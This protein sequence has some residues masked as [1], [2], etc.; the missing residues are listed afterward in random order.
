[1]GSSWSERSYARSEWSRFLHRSVPNPT[2]IAS[3]ERR[4]VDSPCHSVRVTEIAPRHCPYR[5]D[6]LHIL[7]REYCFR[8]MVNGDVVAGRSASPLPEW[9]RMDT[10]YSFLLYAMTPSSLSNNGSDELMACEARKYSSARLDDESWRYSMPINNRG[11]WDLIII[12]RI[13]ATERASR[14][15]TQG[16]ILPRWNK[17]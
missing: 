1:M 10:T 13:H 11:R 7:G 14:R 16:T 12:S 9:R 8:E 6:T 3:T 2:Q 17:Q 15:R 4:R 5:L